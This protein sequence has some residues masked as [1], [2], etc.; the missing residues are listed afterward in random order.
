MAALEFRLARRSEYS[1]IKA[2]YEGFFGE[3][4]YA[5]AENYYNWLHGDSPWARRAA[6]QDEFTALCAFEGDALRACL[7]FTPIDLRVDGRAFRASWTP[8]WLAHPDAGLAAGMLINRYFKSAEYFISMGLSENMKALYAKRPGVRFQDAFPR[9]LM[10]TDAEALGRLLALDP[11]P[12]TRNVEGARR[13]ADEA[14]SAATAY[15][16]KEDADALGEEWRPALAQRSRVYT[17]KTVEYLSWRY[18]RHP[19]IPYA[20]ISDRAEGGGVAVLRLER[21]SEPRMSVGRITEFLP[22]EGGE[23]ALAA[24]VA[25][26]LI[27]KNAAF[28]DFFCAAES[29]GA[30]LPRPFVQPQ[31]HAVYRAPRLF[32][33]LEWRERDSINA[34]LCKGAGW[35]TLP[36]IDF[37]SFYLT[38]GDSSQDVEVNPEYKTRAF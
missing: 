32:Q 29:Y 11:A 15:V 16:L 6:A 23:Q 5:V 17:D 9:W 36:D 35:K 33:P 22:R 34:S 21:I 4:Y 3:N 25:G 1:T 2:F 12:T 18:F 37:S 13:F 26:Y 27:E 20:V 10:I 7:N 8:G 24:A 14:R 19:S 38:K 28:A 30:A 31:E